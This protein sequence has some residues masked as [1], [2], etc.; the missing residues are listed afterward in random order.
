MKKLIYT[1]LSVAIVFSSCSDFLEIDPIAQETES[2]FFETPENAIYAVNACYDIIGMTEGPGPD[3]QWLTHNYEFFFGDLLSDDSEKGS[4][5]SD[6]TDIQDLVEW[7]AT[8]DNGITVSLWV[9]CY[10]GIYRANTV[11]K[12]LENSSLD[13]NLKN[14]LIGEA[15]FIRGYFYF[16]LVKIYGGVPLI[17]T[18]VTPDEFGQLQRASYHQTFEQVIADFKAA[19]ELLPEKSAYDESDL[20]RATK[21]AANTYLARAM[22]Y[23]IGMDAEATIGWGDIKA[24]TANIIGSGEYALASNYATIY[25]MDGENNAESIFELQFIE[26]S[27]ADAPR[28]TG[29]NFHQFQGNR[30]DWGWGFNNPTVNLFDAYEAED[31][32][33]SCVVY[34]ESFNGGVVHGV[35]REYDLGQQMTPYLSR[36]A[37]LEPAF[38]PSI[39]K[40]SGANVR[41]ARYAEVV[42][43]HAE[44]AYHTGDEGTAQEMLELIRDRAR[45]ST[46]AKGS[47]DGDSGYTPTGYSGNLPEIDASGADLLDAIYK[48]RRVELA[49]ESLRFWD[50]VRTGRYLDMLD[51]KK[52]TF[53][54][55]DGSALRYENVD[56]R[57]NCLEKCIDGANGN[58]VPLMPLPMT[59]VQDWDLQQNKG[60]N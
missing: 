26:G 2:N 54:T 17:T 19:A 51:L 46:F 20:G 57:A 42:L 50:L 27:T 10:D 47:V 22:T 8:S 30:K 49:V 11:L 7:R 48:E 9:K 5:E 53:M 37:A 38:R 24:V 34:G 13:E 33:L 40:S 45:T 35:A 58:K 32:R 21:G 44:A 56:L 12:Q 14:R 25:E 3:G 43:M 29:T 59:E 23:Q 15:T 18:P 28:K 4:T 6:F 16:Y 39:D 31:P 36:K 60:Y 55:S 52:A 41:K 1:L